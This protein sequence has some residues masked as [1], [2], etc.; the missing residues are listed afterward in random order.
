MKKLAI[1]IINWNSYEVTRD[2][3]LSLQ[4]TSYRNYDVI[5][6]DNHSTDGSLELLQQEFSD[7]IY[8]T[9]PENIGFTGGNNAGMQY[10]IEHNYTYTLLLNNDVFVKEDFLEPLI[11]QL[12]QDPKMGAVQP[13]IYFHHDR[14]L[15][16]NAG[17][18]YNPWLGICQTIG[19]NK[20]DQP[21]FHWPRTIDWITGCA[22]MVRTELLKEIGVFPLKF[23]IYFEDVDLS[24]RIKQKGYRLGF[25]PDSVIYHIAGVSHKSKEKGKEGFVSPKVH[26]L[27]SRNRIWLLKRYTKA[28]AFPSV[29]IYHLI[30][31]SAIA[32]Y[33]ILRQRWQKL[34]AW[35]RGIKE[36]LLDSL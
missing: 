23:F 20:A 24:F 16:W 33:F 19:Y 6:V 2:T 18:T 12:D 28:I 7:L 11:D 29:I 27:V 25:V 3:L 31:F 22:F 5:L 35:T 8:L 36:G 32:F 4:Q 10:A 17:A 9:L 13:L 30:Y 34:K 26:Y 1:V 14:S 15:I 21:S